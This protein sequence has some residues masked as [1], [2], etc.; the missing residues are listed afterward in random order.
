MLL[1]SVFIVQV[2]CRFCF[3]LNFC[4]YC[5]LPGAVETSVDVFNASII[6]TN[7][8]VV[9][10]PP[11][12]IRSILNSDDS[13]SLDCSI[14][15]DP[16]YRNGT[17]SLGW[18]VGMTGPEHR[19]FVHENLTT[20]FVKGFKWESLADHTNVTVGGETYSVIKCDFPE[21]KVPY[22]ISTCIM[23]LCRRYLDEDVCGDTDF[24]FENVN[25]ALLRHVSNSSIV[26]AI[27]EAP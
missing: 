13:A 3:Y 1:N 9:L 12:I 14:Y 22:C 26:E 21:F 2:F 19:F 10:V 15:R 6:V 18:E 11:D 16:S 4:L 24:D 27:A 8:G 7:P 17:T 20:D 23:L 25:A 5:G